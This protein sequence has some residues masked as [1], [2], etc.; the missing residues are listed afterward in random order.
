MDMILIVSLV[1]AWLAVMAVVFGLT[2]AA[3]GGPERRRARREGAESVASP[4]LQQPERE[5]PAARR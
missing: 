3:G 2:W 5:R 1:L 4:P